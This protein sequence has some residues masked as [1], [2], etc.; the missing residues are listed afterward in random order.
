[1]HTSQVIKTKEHQQLPKFE[2]RKEYLLKS[3]L[4][5]LRNLLGLLASEKF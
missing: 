2:S 3:Q 4:V 5:P 1:M